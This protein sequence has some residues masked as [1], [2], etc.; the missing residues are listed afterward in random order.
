MHSSNSE[1]YAHF[2][3][4]IPVVT[5]AVENKPLI[6]KDSIPQQ[7]R[8]NQFNLNPNK[9][10][11]RNPRNSDSV[12]RSSR[13]YEEPKEGD[14]GC[15][16]ERDSNILESTADG[17]FETNCSRLNRQTLVAQIPKFRL[18]FIA[19]NVRECS[20]NMNP[21]LIT[22]SESWQMYFK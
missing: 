9:Y 8:F 22:D 20:S 16:G 7:T 18:A 6:V 19:L 2:N 21:M 13:V 17:M 14:V 3:E 15:A 1:M 5:N 11:E 12:I 4:N 10:S